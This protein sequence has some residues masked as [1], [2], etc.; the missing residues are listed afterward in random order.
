MPV[1]KATPPITASCPRIGISRSA[2]STPFCSGTT[3]VSGPTIV[4]SCLPTLSTSHNLTQNST[5]VDG[6]N[7]G[8]VIGRLGRPDMGLAAI[9]LD[10]QSV[11]A[12]RREMRATSDKGHVCPGLGK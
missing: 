2:A 11:L 10:T 3:A 8:D 7:A 1:T 5:I 9:S 12:H 4:R 6:A